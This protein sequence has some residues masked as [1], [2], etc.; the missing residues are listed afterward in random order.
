MVGTGSPLAVP[1]GAGQV[2][3]TAVSVNRAPKDFDRRR[4]RKFFPGDRVQREGERKPHAVAGLVAGEILDRG[5]D[6]GRR[7]NGIARSAA[8]RRKQENATEK[9][10]KRKDLRGAFC[11]LKRRPFSIF[12][13]PVSGNYRM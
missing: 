9:T 5:G 8:A 10:G 3:S 13:F 7:R 11:D 12:H 2:N 6:R 1:L 4:R